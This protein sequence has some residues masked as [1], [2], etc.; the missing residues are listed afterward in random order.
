MIKVSQTV[1]LGTHLLKI[2]FQGTRLKSQQSVKLRRADRQLLPNR[3]CVKPSQSVCL[4]F[5]VSQ[6]LTSANDL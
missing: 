1:S 6:P 2:W 3:G 5:S 4:F